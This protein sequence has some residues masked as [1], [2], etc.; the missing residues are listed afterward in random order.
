M[1]EWVWTPEKGSGAGD[2]AGE[3]AIVGVST[4]ESEGRRLGKGAMA[5]RPGPQTSEGERGNGQSALIGRSH[6]ATSENERMRGRISA[7]RSVPPGSGRERGRGSACAIVANRWGPPVRR[8]GRTRVRPGWAGLGL[9][10]CFRFFLFQEIFNA[11][12]FYFLY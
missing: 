4:M 6:R 8:R 12:S 7:D 10:R 1:S 5:D 11:F 3:R 9:M 2:V